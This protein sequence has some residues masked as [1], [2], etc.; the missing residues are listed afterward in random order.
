MLAHVQLFIILQCFLE[1]SC[2]VLINDM[3]IIRC[4]SDFEEYVVCPL[5]TFLYTNLM[6]DVVHCLSYV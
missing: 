2:A 4:A 1:N 3:K 5:I 6:F